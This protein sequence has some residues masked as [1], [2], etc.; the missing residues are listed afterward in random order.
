[1]EARFDPAALIAVGGLSHLLLF[2]CWSS[3]AISTALP[4]VLTFDDLLIREE[5][6]HRQ[7]RLLGITG[8]RLIVTRAVGPP[9]ELTVVEKDLAC[10]EHVL[11]F[12]DRWMAI[13]SMQQHLAFARAHE[14]VLLIRNVH[15]VA[16]NFVQAILIRK[17]VESKNIVRID[18]FDGAGMQIWI[19][20]R[21]LHDT[22]KRFRRRVALDHDR[23]LQNRS[24]LRNCNSLLVLGRFMGLCSM[25]LDRSRCTARIQAAWLRSAR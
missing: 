6:I 24:S 12:R 13:T 5:L 21:R 4:L 22:T 11:P 2:Y 20:L 16:V 1:M 23:F 10:V 3:L 15:T 25:S 8:I 17:T 9:F 7:V 14:V 19:N 18:G